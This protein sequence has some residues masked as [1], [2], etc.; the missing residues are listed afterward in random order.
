LGGPGKGYNTFKQ[1]HN[2]QVN[3]TTVDKRREKKGLVRGGNHLEGKNCTRCGQKV[4]GSTKAASSVQRQ[5]EENFFCDKG[6]DLVW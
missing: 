3:Q 1:Y 2:T 5:R 6:G 4:R